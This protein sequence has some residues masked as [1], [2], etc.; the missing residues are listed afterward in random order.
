MT[1]LS[2]HEVAQGYNDQTKDVAIF[3]KFRVDLEDDDYSNEARK[4]IGGSHLPTYILAWTT[5]P[6]TLPGN[7]ALAI[8]PDADYAVVRTRPTAPSPNG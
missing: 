1:S 6:W 7:T 2:D 5:T 4:L 3:V 8:D